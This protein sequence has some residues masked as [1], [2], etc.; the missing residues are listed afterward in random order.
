MHKAF[1]FRTTPVISPQI[2][3]SSLLAI[4]KKYLKAGGHSVP[5]STPRLAVRVGSGPKSFQE[6]TMSYIQ[7]THKGE[8]FISVCENHWK[9]DPLKSVKYWIEDWL[10]NRHNFP[11]GGAGINAREA[12]IAVLRKDCDIQGNAVANEGK[13]GLIN[14][15]GL[16]DLYIES[17]PDYRVLRV[18]FED[19]E[20]HPHRRYA[21]K[22]VE[23]FCELEDGPP[24]GLNYT[25]VVVGYQFP[26]Q[27]ARDP[28]GTVLI[29]RMAKVAK[30]VSE[31]FSNNF[32]TVSAV[33]LEKMIRDVLSQKQ[34]LRL[35]EWRGININ[36]SLK[37]VDRVVRCPDDN[38]WLNFYVKPMTYM[39]TNPSPLPVV[40]QLNFTTTN[41]YNIRRHCAPD[42][43]TSLIGFTRSVKYEI[44]R[45]THN[46]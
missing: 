3:V 16:C 38:Q 39:G 12:C 17:V 29:Y 35:G 46:F 8:V 9:T 30:A 15:L 25:K 34:A 32:R 1:T 22:F 37:N 2:D 44:D 4:F 5:L 24:C 18:K 11:H 31:F 36:M 10:L 13:R 28:Q 26:D 45:A 23:T 21:E 42:D 6:E 7:A 43:G 41:N 20:R 19:N 27:Y 33:D 14:V 40:V